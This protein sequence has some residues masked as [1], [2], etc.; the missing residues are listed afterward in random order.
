M[1]NPIL[2]SLTV[3]VIFGSSLYYARKHTDNFDG[4]WLTGFSFNMASCFYAG[5]LMSEDVPLHSAINRFGI[6]T[7]AAT[8]SYYIAGYIDKNLPD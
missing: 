4:K 7:S 5:K 2:A 1:N 8:I 3:G 6:I